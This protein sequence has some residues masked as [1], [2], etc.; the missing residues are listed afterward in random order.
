MVLIM[1]ETVQSMQVSATACI[2]V[3]VSVAF[4]GRRP[5]I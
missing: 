2:V 4:A 3:A 5:W 1:I